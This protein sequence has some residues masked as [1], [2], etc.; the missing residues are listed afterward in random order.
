MSSGGE[1]D[2]VPTNDENPDGKLMQFEFVHAVVR[3]A[4][5]KY[6]KAAPDLEG[7]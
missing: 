7:E 3:L 2:Y 1:P 5:A 4:K 6:A